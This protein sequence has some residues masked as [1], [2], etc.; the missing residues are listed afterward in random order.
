M[1]TIVSLAIAISNWNFVSSSGMR[2]IKVAHI[3]TL[4]EL[5]GAQQNTL[6]TV[7]NLNREKYEVI[8][9]CGQGA[10][11]DEEAKKIPN[12][13]LYFLENLV[14]P[15]HP[16]KD[17]VALFQIKKILSA[18]K[19]EIVHT[20]SSKAG[21]LGRIAAYWAGAPHILH[22]IHGFGFN[23]YQK[24]F[25]RNLFIFLEKWMAKI[26]EKLI[27]V[28]KENIET[29]LQ[30]EIGR[31]DQYCL[32]RSGV[33]IQK[34][35]SNNSACNPAQLRKSLNL[36]SDS[37]I[38][39]N[40]APFK[41]QK[42]PLSFVRL[43]VLVRKKMPEC[44]FLMVGDG[45]LRVETESLIQSLQLNDSVKILGWRR[46]IPELLAI[47]DLF[48]LTSLW[49]GLPRAAVE[50]LIVGKPVIAFA[51]DGLKELIQ[52]GKNGFLFPPGTLDSMGEKIVQVLKN[53][54]LRKTLSEN[55]S[56]SIDSSFDIHQMVRDQENLYATLAQ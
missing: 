23:P 55:A 48:A 25:V 5:G 33:D 39:L 26:S 31:R 54:T 51:V 8:L 38:I 30:L 47:S 1:R 49:E 37:K 42:D 34:I 53:E 43:A 6:F 21:I 41:I 2:K 13:T 20:H 27:A 56:Q 15:I 44:R 9:I 40:V 24:L 14:R 11:L 12:L 3:V 50:A 17:L 46:D 36:S 7:A 4:L 32:I 52:D 28:T 29:G 10:F 45:D 35:L 19:P 18:E 22:S 16:I